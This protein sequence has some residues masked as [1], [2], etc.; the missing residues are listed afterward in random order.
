M[1]K[2]LGLVII[3]SVLAVARLWAD[4]VAKP[5]VVPELKEWKAGKGYFVPADEPRI[6][7]PAGNEELLRIARIFAEDYAQM[8]GKRPEV[9][10]GKAKAGD[11]IFSLQKD[12]KLGK[13]G[14]T[15]FKEFYKEELKR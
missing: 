6:V 2:S 13:E 3:L 9:G 4:G 5:F 14:Y 10:T 8:Y 12:S 7:C 15:E 1:K 11:F